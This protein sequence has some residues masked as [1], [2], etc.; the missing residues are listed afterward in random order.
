M[1][2][3]SQVHTNVARVILFFA[4]IFAKFQSVDHKFHQEISVKDSSQTWQ[5][6][7]LAVDKILSALKW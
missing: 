3:F 2:V 1:C 7:F 6:L 5:S 4:L